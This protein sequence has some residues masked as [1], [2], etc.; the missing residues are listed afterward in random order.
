M[1]GL[2]DFQIRP[3]KG[4]EYML[5]KRLKGLVRRLVFPLPTK[6]TKGTLIIPTFDG[7][8]MVGPTAEDVEDRE[9]VSTTRR[10][11]PRRSSPSVRALCPAIDPRDAIT[12]FAGLRAVSSTND[13]V[14]GPTAVKGFFNVAGI[15]SPG[16]TAAPAIAE[17]V[18]GAARRARG[19]SS[20]R[21]TA[22]SP[23]VAGPTRFALR[24]PRGA[25]GARRA[26]TRASPRSSA[27]ASW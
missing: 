10:G 15:Q 20:C 11:A 19:W 26:R 12:A 22:T 24:T 6:T 18:R 23:S 3:R 8:I 13:F 5:D 27:A 4:E 14:I 17:Y 7:T 1:V 21:A 25:G 2:D 16:L 9:D